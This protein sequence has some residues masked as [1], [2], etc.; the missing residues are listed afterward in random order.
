[1]SARPAR[2]ASYN[3]DVTEAVGRIVGPN[4]LGEW[5][6]VVAADYDASTDRTRLSFAFN[7][8]RD[9]DGLHLIADFPHAP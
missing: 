8:R 4:T 3:G 7:V 5:M 6:Q 2:F 9:A 1:M